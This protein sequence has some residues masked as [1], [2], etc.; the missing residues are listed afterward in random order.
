M[1]SFVARIKS[2][3]GRQERQSVRADRREQQFD[4]MTDRVGDHKDHMMDR[5][6]SPDDT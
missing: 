6:E 2:W 1:P 3:F 5:I 4:E